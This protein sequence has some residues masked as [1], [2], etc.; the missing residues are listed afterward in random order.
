VIRIGEGPAAADCDEARVTVFRQDHTQHPFRCRA[1]R[2][3][4]SRRAMRALPD[5]AAKRTRS[6]NSATEW[7]Q[8][9]GHFPGRARATAGRA[10]PPA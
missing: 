7:R 9:A 6:T 8:S 5:R 3:T 4:Q 2:G 10:A 1:R